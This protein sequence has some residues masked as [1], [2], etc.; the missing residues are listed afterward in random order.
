MVIFSSCTF[1]IKKYKGIIFAIEHKR[2]RHGRSFSHRAL[3]VMSNLLMDVGNIYREARR[4]LIYCFA[5]K[6]NSIITKFDKFLG[7]GKIISIH[8]CLILFVIYRLVK[9]NSSNKAYNISRNRNYFALSKELIE[10][11]N[12]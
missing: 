2:R 8:V 7:K 1:A 4:A 5:L 12:N 3:I 6:S 9:S 10:F 11:S